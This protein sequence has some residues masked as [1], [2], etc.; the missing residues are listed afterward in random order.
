ILSTLDLLDACARLS[1]DL[2]APPPQLP[3]G[4]NG[5]KLDLR[6]A[7]HPLMVLSGRACVPSDLVVAVGQ[8][9]VIS[10]PNAG[11]KTVALKT[12]GLAALMTRAG[13]HLT[14]ESGS[15]MGWFPDVRTDIGDAQSL[16]ANLSTFSGHVVA[17]RE[18]LAT[19]G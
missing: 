13:L 12:C 16:E 18:Y 11:G 4:K 7:R 3:H 10:G 9:L 14:A 8:T 1:I 17:L 5:A 6:R 19:A 2:R 15:V